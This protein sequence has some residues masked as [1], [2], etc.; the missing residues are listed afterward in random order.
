MLCSR[1]LQSGVNKNVY[2]ADVGPRCELMG[3]A[4]VKLSHNR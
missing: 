4:W 2:E 1:I 3:K